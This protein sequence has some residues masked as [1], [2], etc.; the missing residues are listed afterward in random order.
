MTLADAL[1][2]LPLDAYRGPTLEVARW[3]I[4]KMLWSRIDGELTGGIIVETE[5]YVASVDPAAHG[6]RGETPRTRS[7][8][9]P[10]GHAYV[11]VSYGQHHCLNVVTEPAGEAAAVLLRALEPRVGLDIMRNRRGEHCH[12]RDLCRGPGRL[13]QALGITLREDGAPLSGP[14]LWI[15]EASQGHQWAVATSRRIG[16]SRAVEWPWRFFV[17]GSRFVSRGMP[18]GARPDE[19]AVQ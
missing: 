17:P 12:D 11:Y 4:G 8:F 13:C 3:L 5:A 1:P 6:Y 2:A 7:M 10:P 19:S 18:R 14:D 16:I 9:G 15:A